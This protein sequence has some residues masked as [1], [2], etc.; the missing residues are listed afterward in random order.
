MNWNAIGVGVAAVTAVAT[1]AQAWAAVRPNHPAFVTVESVILAGNSIGE[2][3]IKHFG[4]VE[5]RRLRNTPYALAGDRF[6][7]KLQH[8]FE[9]RWWYKRK[10]RVAR[11]RDIDWGN[12][13]VVQSVEAKCR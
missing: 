2:S 12:I 1:V 7:P 10:R 5:L 9:S 11:L 3:D 8:H 4:C 6:E 13:T